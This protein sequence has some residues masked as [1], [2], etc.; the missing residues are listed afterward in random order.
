MSDPAG[1][2]DLDL[3][4][5]ASSLHADTGDVRILLKALVAKLAD[6]LGPRLVV[7]RKGGR[8]RKSDDIERLV[9]TLGDDQLEAKVEAGACVCSVANSSGGIR[10]RS[11]RVTMDEWLRQ[12]LSALRDEARTS[13]ATRQALESMVI[14]GET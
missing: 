1:G 11:A 2:S 6:A 8:I 9:V 10:I 14:G 5:L 13:Q 3:D 12:L 7:E 4:L